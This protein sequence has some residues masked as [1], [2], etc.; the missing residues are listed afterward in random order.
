[1]TSG[2]LGGLGLVAGVT[3][4]LFVRDNYLYSMSEKMDDIQQDY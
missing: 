4:G 3:I 1:M 2:F